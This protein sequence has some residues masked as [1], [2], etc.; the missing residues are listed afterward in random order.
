MRP[1]LVALGD[2]IS[3]G[4]GVGVGVDIADAWVGVLARSLDADLDVLATP[5]VRTSHVRE[6]QLPA[7]VA[8]RATYATLLIGLN[9]MVAARFD[10]TLV[11]DDI[12]TTVR[13]LRG[14]GAA[15]V[16]ARLHDPMA[17]IPTPGWVRR[18]FTER[19]DVINSAVD[20]ARAPGVY[21]VDL[22]CIPALRTRGAWSLDRVH[23]GLTGHRAIAAAAV[24]A[25][26][27]GGA[28]V[29]SPIT[30][31]IVLHTHSRLAEIRWL[32]QHGA[33]YLARKA[34]ERHYRDWETVA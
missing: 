24:T 23:P 33:P 11:R 10:A 7:A 28:H 6:I 32:A 34:R 12:I 13:E 29:P 21:V 4:E 30:T 16:L 8:R 15:V 2:S 31:P 17:L 14:S 18:R 9:D 20:E 25:L 3:C 22:G 27:S 19:I 1:K 26:T 5:G